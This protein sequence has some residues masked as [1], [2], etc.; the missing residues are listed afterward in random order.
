MLIKAFAIASAT[1]SAEE[2]RV[3]PGEHCVNLDYR[4]NWFGFM[5]L[6][7]RLRLRTSDGNSWA[8]PELA[9][10]WILCIVLYLVLAR[11]QGPVAYA[12]LGAILFPII[13]TLVLWFLPRDPAPDNQ[14]IVYNYTFIPRTV[15]IFRPILLLAGLVVACRA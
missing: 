6:A 7:L 8:I 3:P 1:H 12:G 5:T 11:A 9:V 10:I 15:L 13:V 14:Y 4:D 2:S